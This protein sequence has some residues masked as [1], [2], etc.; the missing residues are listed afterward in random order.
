M[1][2]WLL[3]V[4][5]AAAIVIG[6]LFHERNAHRRA[7][8][9]AAYQKAFDAYS[10]AAEYR[11][12]G[13]L[14]FEPQFQNFEA[15]FD[16]FVETPAPYDPSHAGQDISKGLGLSNCKT[17]LDTYRTVRNNFTISHASAQLTSLLKADKQV[18]SCVETG[19]SP[20]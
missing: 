4:L 19:Q 5:F 1:K 2:M 17:I 12:D 14:F 3:L 20:D 11:N 13:A 18:R 15:A 7:A 8:W 10:R 6:F 9:D 16:E